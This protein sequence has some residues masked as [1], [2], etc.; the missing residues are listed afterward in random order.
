MGFGIELIQLVELH[1]FGDLLDEIDRLQYLHL[2]GNGQFIEHGLGGRIG[3]LRSAEG[4]GAGFDEH[5][6]L[7]LVGG[8]HHA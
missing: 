6:R 2:A 5:A 4:G 7:A 1:V 8:R 3:L